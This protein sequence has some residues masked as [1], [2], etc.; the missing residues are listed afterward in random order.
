VHP[1]D[2]SLVWNPFTALIMSRDPVGF[3]RTYEYNVSP[4]T[5]DAPFFFFTLKFRHL[6]QHSALQKGID[7][8]VNLG[9]LVL[10]VLLAISIVAVLAFL[11]LPLALHAPARGESPWRLLYFIS[12]GLGYILVEITLIQRFVLFLGH[13]VYALTV[14]VFLMLLSSGL[15]SL[16]SRRS[17][18]DAQRI[19]V[20]ALIV[21]GLVF[22]YVIGLPALLPRIV[23]VSFTLKLL[24]SAALLIPIGFIMGM[25]FP[26]GLRAMGAKSGALPDAA[27]AVAHPDNRVEWAWALNAAASVLGSVVAMFLAIGWGLTTTLIS[28]ALCYL[29]AAALSRS[30]PSTARS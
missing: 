20:A 4:V 1:V 25:P 16:A 19:W 3:A 18:R 13:P 27:R 22:L 29:I 30:F 6:V 12:I 28:A 23:G 9:V 2:P 11:V 8:K 14:V 7:W 15:G 17:L 26:A 10:F 21:A 5:D 24:V